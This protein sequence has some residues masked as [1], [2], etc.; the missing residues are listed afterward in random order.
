MKSFKSIVIAGS[1]F[2]CGPSVQE[3]ACLTTGEINISCGRNTR[4]NTLELAKVI[5]E[6]L[7]SGCLPITPI[8]PSLLEIVT[9]KM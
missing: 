2:P 6:K 3:A 7:Q 5:Q 1:H 4:E 9:C 8:T